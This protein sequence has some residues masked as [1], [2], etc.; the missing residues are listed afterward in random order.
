MNRSNSL[1]INEPQVIYKGQPSR[2]SVDGSNLDLKGL[3]I[4]KKDFEAEYNK[5]IREWFFK[6]FSKEQTEE[7][8]KIFY[9]YL[10]EIEINIYFF[11]WFSQYC[12][13]NKIDYP[14]K[15]QIKTLGIIDNNWKTIDNEVIRSEYPPQQTITIE[16]ARMEIEA[17]PFKDTIKDLDKAVDKTDIKKLHSQMNYSNTVLGVMSKQLTRIEGIKA[18]EN[19]D[20]PSTSTIDVQFEERGELVQNSF[21]GSEIVEWN[22]DGLSDQAILDI[23]CQMTMAATT[24]K[25][26]GCSDKSAA[27]AIIQGF[28]GQLK[29]WWDNLCTDNDRAIILNSVK[30]ETNQED[31]VATLIYTIIQNFIGDPNIFKERAGDQLNNLYC[32]SMSDYRWYKDVFMS[33]VTLREDGF[34]NYWKEK[35]ISGLPKLFSEK[36]KTNLERYHGH[37]IRYETLTYGQLHNIVVQTGIQIC[38][39]FRLQNKMRKESMS[40]KRELGTFCHQY[41]VEPI[42]APSTRHKKKIRQEKS[43]NRKHKIYRKTIHNEKRINNK[44]QNHQVPAKQKYKKKQKYKTTKREIKCYKC[45]KIGHYANKCRII[46]KINQLEDKLLKYIR[47]SYK[48]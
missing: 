48:I 46:Q 23:T 6:T 22:I 47:I 18:L 39:D 38:T 32:P 34:A 11:D 25:T 5:E 4:N 2:Y 19:K 14:F 44:N 8:R 40:N 27:L 20:L 9:E 21:S 30:N 45:G 12:E 37:P 15:K 33:K 10:E 28:T 36:V 26:R 17:S 1:K 41:G 7:Y 13:K 42:R 24:H 31:A 3:N 29:G 43:Y 16:F 35:F